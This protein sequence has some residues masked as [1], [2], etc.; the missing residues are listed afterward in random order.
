MVK[1]HVWER[2]KHVRVGTLART[3][4]LGNTYVLVRK[5]VRVPRATR[6]CCYPNTYDLCGRRVRV[7]R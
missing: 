1:Q 6:T 7:G 3:I 4:Y 2:T 5:R